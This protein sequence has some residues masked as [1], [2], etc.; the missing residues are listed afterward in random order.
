[1]RGR[2]EFCGGTNFNSKL[3]FVLQRFVGGQSFICSIFMCYKADVMLLRSQQFALGV[4]SC[5]L[6]ACEDRVV[7]RKF[8]VL[9]PLQILQPQ[10]CNHSQPGA[11]FAVQLGYVMYLYAYCAHAKV[12]RRLRPESRD[13]ARWCNRSEMCCRCTKFCSRK[14]AIT[15]NQVLHLLCN[16]DM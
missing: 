12:H 5:T 9:L 16:L 6:A 7:F 3:R 1:M 10:I 14:S 13:I 4:D 11:A 15:R 2:T 8:N